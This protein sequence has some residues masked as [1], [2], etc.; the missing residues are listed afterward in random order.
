M[1][2]QIISELKSQKNERIKP[3]KIEKIEIAPKK[4]QW[5]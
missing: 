4:L 5:H 1:K 3:Q 2:E